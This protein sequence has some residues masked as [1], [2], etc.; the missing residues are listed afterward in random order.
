MSSVSLVVVCVCILCIMCV[1]KV[2]YYLLV[3]NWEEV[4]FGSSIVIMQLSTL[5]FVW[6]CQK[7]SLES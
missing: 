6:I 2:C 7:V 3:V 4:I 5:F 1:C